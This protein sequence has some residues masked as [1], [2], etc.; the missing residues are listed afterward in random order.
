MQKSWLFSVVVLGLLIGLLG[1]VPAQ[2]NSNGPEK[3]NPYVG[4]SQAISEGEELYKMLNCYGCHGLK[5]GG[6]MGP[7]LTDAEWKVGDG[8]DEHLLRQVKEGRGNMPSYEGVIDEDQAW[9]IISFVRSLYKG[10]PT[11]V[12]W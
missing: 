6:G 9:K 2:E 11:T 4:N 1:A 8:S 5:G 3:L 7:S 10:D 12:N